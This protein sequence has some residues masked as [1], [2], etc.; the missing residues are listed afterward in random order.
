MVNVFYD[1]EQGGFYDVSGNDKSLLMK[2]KETYDAA[3]PSGNSTAIMDLLRIA[4]YTDNKDLFEKAKKSLNFFSGELTE[5]PSAMPRMLSALD[6]YLQKPMQIIITGSKDSP[7][8]QSLL[9]EV[10]ARYIPNKILILA[11]GI[12]DKN[13]IPYLSSIIGASGETLA[14]VCENYACKLPTGDPVRLGKLLDNTQ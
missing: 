14:Y 3:Q 1:R 8:T 9:K 13:M 11:D 7:G 6:Y 12:E 10:D 5:R 4:Q 2:T